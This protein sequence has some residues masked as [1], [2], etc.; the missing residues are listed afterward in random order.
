MGL[1]L[2]EMRRDMQGKKDREG[3]TEFGV[4]GWKE[5]FMCLG[6]MSKSLML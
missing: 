5:Y 1:K 4:G 6:M 2:E 3:D